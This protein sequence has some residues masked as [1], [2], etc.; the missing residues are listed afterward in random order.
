MKRILSYISKKGEDSLKMTFRLLRE[1]S[2]RIAA[3]A[4]NLTNRSTNLAVHV[5]P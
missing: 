1:P 2:P 5:N 3:I 4:Q